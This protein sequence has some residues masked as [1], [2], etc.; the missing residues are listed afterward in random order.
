MNSNATS[1]A[2]LLSIS[3][4]EAIQNKAL[5]V[6]IAD[7]KTHVASCLPFHAVQAMMQSLK[8][9]ALVFG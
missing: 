4:W 2:R 1:A 8:I 5:L 9:N 7:M 6:P 3:S